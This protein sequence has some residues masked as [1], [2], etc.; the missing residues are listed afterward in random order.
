MP[1]DFRPL[2]QDEDPVVDIPDEQATLIDHLDDLKLDLAIMIDRVDT[3]SKIAAC[4]TVLS[5]SSK[6]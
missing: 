6:N 2:V 1:F 5:P 3:I 4:Q